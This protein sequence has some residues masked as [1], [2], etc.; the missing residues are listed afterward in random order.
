[1][2]DTPGPAASPPA[3]DGTPFRHTW[4]H[5]AWVIVGVAAM[6][7]MVGASIRLTFGVFIDPLVDGFGWSAGSVSLAYS[8]GMIVTAVFSPA[9]GWVGIRY[10]A[11]KAMVAG[12]LLFLVGMIGTAAISELWHLYFWYGLVLGIAQALFLVPLLPSVAIWF[13]RYLGMGSGI[14][15]ISWGLGPAIMVQVM[16]LLI[17]ASGWRGTF[18]VS[19]IVGTGVMLLLVIVFRNSPSDRG[20]QA[21]GW[22][23]GDAATVTSGAV[24]LE[25]A[26]AFQRHIRGTGA[27][28][29]LINIHLMGCVGHAVVLLMIVPFATERGLSIGVAAGVL[30]TLSAASLL[31]RFGGPMFADRFGSKGVMFAAY[32]IQAV[33]V[34]MLFSSH[35]APAL[36]VFAVIYGIGYGGEGTIFAI[37][38]RQYYGQTPQSS[39]YGWQ[40]L[41][42]G[43]GMAIG[44]ALAGVTHDLTG[45]YTT[46]I[47]FSAITSG[48]GAASIVLLPATKR[49]LIPD[50]D[51]AITE[52]AGSAGGAVVA[53]MGGHGDSGD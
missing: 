15:M 53:P 3:A 19:G 24:F 11:R 26:R 9:A 21:Y 41:G 38:N 23:P 4:R 32:F 39:T 48:L 2:S 17:A 8:A 34:L 16:A 10:G 5:Y 37:I 27:F 28:W 14:V 50:W 22:Q 40:I 36:Y 1:M 42:A 20:G 7:Q 35:S 45:S 25:I 51:R 43:I 12:S 47:V 31:T 52:E 30:S 44:G 13:R 6:A 29:N 46:A 49:L 18:I 33:A